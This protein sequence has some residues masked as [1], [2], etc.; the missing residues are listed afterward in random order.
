MTLSS[1][2]ILIIAGEASGDMHGAALV[3][4]LKKIN[5]SLSFFGVGGDKMEKEGVS[6]VEHTDKMAI[7]GFTEVLTRYGFLKKVFN[8]VI[9]LAIEVQP[10]R[11]ILID[12]PGFNLKLSKKLKE[13]NILVT[14]YIPPQ[15]WAWHESRIEV[16]KKYVDQVICIFPFEKEWYKKRGI[17]VEFVGH[18]FLDLKEEMLSKT[19]FL[20]KHRIPEEAQIV[21]LFPGSR[22]KE[23][24]RHLPIMLDTIKRLKKENEKIVCIVGKAKDVTINMPNANYFIV[25]ENTPVSALRYSDVAIVASGTVTLE[26]ALFETPTVVIYKLSAISG[27]L[28]K[29]LVK[30]KFVSMPNLIANKAVF[31]ELLLSDGTPE[32]IAAEV[33]YLLQ[34]S[35]RRKEMLKEIKK[36]KMRLGRPGASRK[37]ANLI[38]KVIT[39]N[40]ND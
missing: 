27:F 30:V 37:A 6:L 33:K 29:L 25:E 17:N 20:K 40:K 12:Y 14:Y 18:P 1:S 16:L 2:K 7:M 22:Q 13:Q 10:A 26:A 38:N 32:K 23:V 15:L 39:S 5:P 24:N 35:T 8:K 21:S 9:D 3:A 34:S 19:Q 31:P 36:I 11:A 4:E 28:A